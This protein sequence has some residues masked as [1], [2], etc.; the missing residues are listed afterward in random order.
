MKNTITKEA[1]LGKIVATITKKTKD[2]TAKTK[3]GASHKIA[4]VSKPKLPVASKMSVMRPTQAPTLSIPK[5]TKSAKTMKFIKLR[6]SKKAKSTK[7]STSYVKRMMESAGKGMPSG[8]LYK[9]VRRRKFHDVLN[10][11][12]R[13]TYK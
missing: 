1:M 5:L 8:S 7:P 9:R 13:P 3:P 6:V 10:S 2:I 12:D 11:L 4:K